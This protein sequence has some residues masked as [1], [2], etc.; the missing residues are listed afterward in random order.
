M[1]EL[2]LVVDGRSVT[3]DATG[4]SLLEVL[5]D[6]LHIVS[7]KDGCSPQGQCG[8][9]TVLVDGQPRVACVTPAARVAGRSIT[10]FDGL[11]AQTRTAWTEALYGTGGTQCG[12]C[13]PGIVVR[14]T[15][16]EPAPAAV[17][18][19]LLAHVCRC[20]GWQ[21][22]VE[23]AA[24]VD[25]DTRWP[26]RDLE[27]ASQRA[28]LEGARPQQVGPHVAAGAVGFADDTAPVD[29]LVAMRRPDGTWVVG[30]TPRE[31][32]TR[33]GVVPGRR[34]TASVTWPLEVPPGLWART[35]VTTW[36]EPAYV[37][38]DASWCEPGGEPASPLA[39]GGAFGAKEASPVS[40]VAR[41]L[42]HE[43]GQAVRVRL[44]REDVVRLGPKRP[45]MALAMRADGTGVVRAVRTPGLAEAVAVWAPELVVEEFDVA[46]P[47]TSM[48]VRGAVWAEIAAVRSSLTPGPDTVTTPEGASCTA[49]VDDEGVHIRVRAGNPLDETVLRSYVIGAAHQAVGWVRSEG[50]AVDQTGEV[51][52]LTMRSFGMVRAVDTPHVRVEVEPDDGPPVAVAPAVMA[53]VA[54]AVWRHA[55][56]PPA[57]PVAR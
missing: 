34:T 19:A 22:I 23:A 16:T 30:D 26:A 51:H 36:V 12:F 41:R 10:T 49:W 14:L 11:P 44:T 43:H 9:C 53:A 1:P 17:Q 13:T 45:P 33:A 2:R 57:W 29:A 39:N 24:A 52:D 38:L 7:V 55:G 54:A 6:H 37:E 42:A 3:V 5:R 21:T 28:T 8:C 18:R 47:P 48:D 32:R 40:E 25:C 4:I 46:G 20:T 15:Q 50:L 35:L 31:A 27:A 56:F